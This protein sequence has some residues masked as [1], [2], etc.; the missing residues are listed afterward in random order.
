ML[1]PTFNKLLHFTL[2]DGSNKI[3]HARKNNSDWGFV[4]KNSSQFYHPDEV[5][6]WGYAFSEVRFKKFNEFN[7]EEIKEV[8]LYALSKGYKI[9]CLE[10]EPSYTDNLSLSWEDKANY[11]LDESNI[12]TEDGTLKY[13]YS[14]SD[15]IVTN[16]DLIKEEERFFLFHKEFDEAFISSTIF[17]DLKRAIKEEQELQL[18]EQERG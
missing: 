3:G 18:E 8:L 2:K 13:P 16:W 9:E 7:L 6:R 17:N 5:I 4:D 11:I 1:K 15:E 12:F 10:T 14:Y